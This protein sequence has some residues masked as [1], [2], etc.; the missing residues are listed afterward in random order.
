MINC[1]LNPKI[2]LEVAMPTLKIRQPVIVMADG[3]LHLDQLELG[4]ARIELPQTDRISGGRNGAPKLQSDESRLATDL[5][6]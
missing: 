5:A 3:L 2:D 1:G 6:K 4:L